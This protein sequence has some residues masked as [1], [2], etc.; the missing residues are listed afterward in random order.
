M[1]TGLCVYIGGNAYNPSGYLSPQTKLNLSRTT[2]DKWVSGSQ[3]QRR[4]NTQVCPVSSTP[5][6][7]LFNAKLMA[8]NT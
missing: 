3:W 7:R 5:Q 6:N 2:S 1:M 4:V 8:K